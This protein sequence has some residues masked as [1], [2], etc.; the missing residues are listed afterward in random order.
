MRML[1]HVN[2]DC[3]GR[4]RP[5]QVSQTMFWQCDRCGAVGHDCMDNHAAAIRENALG[6]T[7]SKLAAE[8]QKLLSEP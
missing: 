1:P 2:P 7:L 5:C 4:W 6:E 8:G 3:P